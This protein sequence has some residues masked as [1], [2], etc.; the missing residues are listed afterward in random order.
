MGCGVGV[1]DLLGGAGA[2]H[3]CGTGVSGAAQN[4]FREA[5]AFNAAIGSWDV[6]KVTNMRVRRRAV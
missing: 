4:M 5:H 2:H 6:G 3:A 1:L